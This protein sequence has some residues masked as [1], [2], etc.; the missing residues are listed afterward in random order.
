MLWPVPST[1]TWCP[2]AAAAVR[3]PHGRKGHGGV[4]VQ[5]IGEDRADDPPSP[6]GGQ[7]QGAFQRLVPRVR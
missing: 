4:S 1:T 7:G 6:P 2:G 3:L 5:L